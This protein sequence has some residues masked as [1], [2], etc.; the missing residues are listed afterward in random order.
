EE[1]GKG[2][3]NLRCL[4][5]S[6][7]IASSSSTAY[8]FGSFY[9]LST[10]KPISSRTLPFSITPTSMISRR[11]V[12]LSTT[13]SQSG[14]TRRRRLRRSSASFWARMLWYSSAS[15]GG[16]RQDKTIEEG[17]ED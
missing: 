16:K 5:A 15:F 11:F 12:C 1:I 6:T 9:K 17:A 13:S 8:I 7:S 14:T 4:R 10:G 2:T 3:I